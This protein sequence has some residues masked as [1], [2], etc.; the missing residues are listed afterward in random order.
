MFLSNEEFKVIRPEF[1]TRNLNRVQGQIFT[2]E[3]CDMIWE[4]FPSET[5][6][7]S[8]VLKTNKVH[9]GVY[10][11]PNISKRTE[12]IVDI[13]KTLSNNISAK[14]FLDNKLSH[15]VK[16]EYDQWSKIIRYVEGDYLKNHI[17]SGDTEV[18]KKRE[19]TLIVQLSD[20]S[21]YTGGDF[22]IGDWIMPKTKGFVCLF[23]GGVVP[24]EV[25]TITSGERKS[26]ISW[27]GKKD[28][29]FL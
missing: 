15:W 6:H 9:E 3:E 8:T 24:H 11:D 19:W 29:T 10:Y 17:D 13:N 14:Q 27:L 4:E 1:S 21:E 2:P 22:K 20:E 26:F 18:L 25:T 5:L 28:L 7:T 23:N 12:A 16:G